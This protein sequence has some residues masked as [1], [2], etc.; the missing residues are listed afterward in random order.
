[1]AIPTGAWWH[2]SALGMGLAVLSKGPPAVFPVLFLIGLAGVSG[3]WRVL[4]AWVKSGAPLTLAV[5]ALPWFVYVHQTVGWGVLEEEAGVVLAGEGHK[6]PV[7]E[8]ALEGFLVTLPWVGFV[9]LGVFDSIKRWREDVR[10]RGLLVWGL[11]VFAPLLMIGQKQNHYLLPMMPPAMLLAGWILDRAL[12]GRDKA[13]RVA[14]EIVMGATAV[15]FAA[16]GVGVL[17]SARAG[18]GRIGGVDGVVAFS[19]A[20]AGVGV[21]VAIFKKRLG[22]GMTAMVGGGTIAMALVIGLW[23]PSMEGMTYREVAKRIEERFGEGPYAFGPNSEDLSLSYSLRRVVPAY[24][25]EEG[26]AEAVAKEPGLVVMVE[27]EEEERPA[28][29]PRGMVERERVG[30]DGKVIVVYRGRSEER[31]VDGGLMRGS[32]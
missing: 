19:L 1:M 30:V 10:W 21:L 32:E 24:E 31:K 5:V 28:M 27:E 16:A 17:V 18:H 15:G 25:T 22:A 29:R 4:W 23:E 3:R 2:L 11:A 8:F 14:V 9:V 6:D 26:L 12:D 7:W 13:L 20:A